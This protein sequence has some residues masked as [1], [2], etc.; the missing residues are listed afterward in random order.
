MTERVGAARL[1]TSLSTLTRRG[2]LTSR[3]TV[4][5][6]ARAR[7]PDERPARGQSR[8][9]ECDLDEVADQK[10]RDAQ[11][12]SFDAVPQGERE[13][14]PAAGEDDERAERHRRRR[15]KVSPVPAAL[16][17]VA[18]N[19]GRRGEG[20]QVAGGQAEERR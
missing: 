1:I 12:Q 2:G 6:S 17:Q 13:P 19:E 4:L 20:E 9:G 3:G 14:G 11:S 8:G 5:V 16:G 18:R 15:R 10:R 7:A